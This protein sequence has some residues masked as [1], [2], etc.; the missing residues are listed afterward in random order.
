MRIALSIERF[1]PGL[2]GVES[3]A[4][5]LACELALRGCDL[6]VF[7]R[8]D[9]GAA[10]PSIRRVHC[11]VPTFWQPLRV[12]WFSHATRRA[13]ASSPPFD[14][15]HAFSRTRRQHIYRA[16]GGSHAAYLERSGPAGLGRW[17]PRHRAILGIEEAVF[18][19]PAQIIQ[20]NSKLAAREIAT[21]YDVP[22]E[23]LV[24]IY[25]GVDTVRFDP[26]NREA[27]RQKLMPELTSRYALRGPIALFVGSG[28]ERKGLTSAI[29]GLAAGSARAHLLVAGRGATASYAARAER[30]GVAD[31]VHFLGQRGDVEALHAVSDLM[32]L[33]TRYDSFANACF[34]AMA[35][36]LPV[37]TT[38]SNGVAE[39]LDHGRSGLVCDGD[40]APAFSRLDDLDG[41]RELGAAARVTALAHTWS[42]HADEVIALYER[43]S[44]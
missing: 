9:S 16:G 23:R 29:D 14:I 4:H 13:V 42:Q 33:P 12:A 11:A 21:R 40:F 10:P 15:V 8:A 3:A 34:E 39:L 37:A 31:R 1:E 22:A 18:R 27:L 32:V 25:N 6:T 19:D 24:T 35:S 26:G 2:G 20:C 30:L 17:S 44:R 7:C 38:A 36:G 41:L 5:H 28:F 43:F